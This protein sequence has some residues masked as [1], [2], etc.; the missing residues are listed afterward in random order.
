MRILV[1]DDHPIF[2]EA[3]AGLVRRCLPGCEVATAETLDGLLRHRA[4]F[5]PDL[6]LADYSMPGMG[7]PG[8]VDTL[9]RACPGVPVILMSGVAGPEEVQASMLRG[10]RAFIPKTLSPVEFGSVL[11]LVLRGGSFSGS[12]PAAAPA[13]AE[14]GEHPLT[15]REAEVLLGIVQGKSNKTIA[16]DLS[17][18]EITVKLHARRIFQKLG[19]RNRAEAAALAVKRRLVP[20]A[21]GL[22]PA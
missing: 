6:I 3:V 7:D 16:R 14:A 5:R 21:E 8:G 18:Q 2:L 17:L 9:C 15:P 1:A 22:A 20:D 19:V 12:Q 13:P 11:S 4:D 10:A